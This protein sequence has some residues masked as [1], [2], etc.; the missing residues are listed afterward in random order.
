M[1]W[2]QLMA[3]IR[4]PKTV[5]K[6]IFNRSKN[7]EFF[8]FSNVMTDGQSKNLILFTF[9]RDDGQTNKQTNIFGRLR[10]DKRS[11]NRAT[12]RGAKKPFRCSLD[13]RYFDKIQNVNCHKIFP[14]HL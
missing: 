7:P 12:L 11:R 9:K 8:L 2:T 3:K 13:K 1:S 4:A 5:I 10:S 14:H 6:I